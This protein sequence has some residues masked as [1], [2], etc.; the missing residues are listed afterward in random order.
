MSINQM[1]LLSYAILKTQQSNEDVYF[2]HFTKDEFVKMYDL[3]GKW[4]SRWKELES[5]CIEL[6]RIVISIRNDNGELEIFNPFHRIVAKPKE[7]ILEFQ[8]HEDMVKEIVDLQKR[9]SQINLELMS[10]LKSVYSWELYEYLLGIAKGESRY[11]KIFTRNELLDVFEIEADSSYSGNISLFKKK[12]LIP[13]IDEINKKTDMNITLGEDDK[14]KGKFISEFILEWGVQEEDYTVEATE[15]LQYIMSVQ[16]L[17]MKYMT[18]DFNENYKPSIL[19]AVSLVTE[20][21]VRISPTSPMNRKDFDFVKGEIDNLINTIEGYKKLSDSANML[22]NAKLL[23]E[24]KK[25]DIEKIP[26]PTQNFN[27]A[28]FYNWLEERE[29]D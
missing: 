5:D 21:L 15:L 23:S 16:S 25:Q 29:N 13:S 19:S 12:V 4:E 9:Y 7:K 18:G 3:K 27:K 11:K 2:G 14:N 8:W 20:K 10:Q 17:S 26:K 24:V 28:P 1:R 6:G 22:E